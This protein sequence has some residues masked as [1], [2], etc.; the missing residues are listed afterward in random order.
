MESLDTVNQRLKE[1][2]GRTVDTGQVNWRIVWSD[3]QYEQRYGEYVDYSESGLY[4]RTVT[5][6]RKVLKYPWINHRYVL[7][8]LSIVPMVHNTELHTKVSYEPI[9][10]FEADNGEA[11]PVKWEPAK[12]IIDTLLEGMGDKGTRYKEPSSEEQLVEEQQRIDKLQEELFGNET[13]TTSALSVK[14]GIVV[15]RNYE[16]Q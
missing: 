9:Y 14:E 4:L 16:R 7:E 5:E 13:D 2:Y 8:R 6:S 3:D 12:F 10:T 1:H 15:P 11:L